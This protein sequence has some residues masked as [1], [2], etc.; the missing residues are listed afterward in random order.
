MIEF[1][2]PSLPLK[3]SAAVFNPA[4]SALT[5]W[6]SPK[7]FRLES[8][9]AWI[10]EKAFGGEQFQQFWWVGPDFGADRAAMNSL[11]SA[12]T[13]GSF[14]QSQRAPTITFMNGAVLSFKDASNQNSLYSD[15]VRACT[16]D[17]AVLIPERSWTALQ[18][19]LA[20]TRAPVRLL[21]TC[22]GRGHWFHQLCRD[23]ERSE[24]RERFSYARYAASDAVTDGLL[25][26][27]D[28]D[29]ARSTLPD[30]IF[31]ALYLAEP[32]DER[33]EQAHRAGDSKLMSDDELAIIANIS[34]AELSSVPNSV[35]Q[36]LADA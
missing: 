13:P 35:L 15:S 25:D 19:S 5:E 32:Y 1:P 20:N 29:Y 10:I 23:A 18:Q 28:L 8:G 17:Q 16:V 36:E 12:L 26:P 33:I 14:T 2:R 9:L 4:L 21:S 31:R 30:H 27:A 3:A 7:S 24:D 6:C 11:K 34:P 22:A